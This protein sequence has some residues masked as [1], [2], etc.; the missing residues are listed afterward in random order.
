MLLHNFL[1]ICEDAW[2]EEDIEFFDENVMEERN[3]NTD[4][5]NLRLHVQAR[6]LE[7]H[8]LHRR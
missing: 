6:A 4:A 8:E 3:L 5:A 7:W 1:I 2:E